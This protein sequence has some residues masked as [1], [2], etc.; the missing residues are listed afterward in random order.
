MKNRLTPMRF[1]GGFDGL[2]LPQFG[3]KKKIAELLPGNQHS[4]RLFSLSPEMLCNLCCNKFESTD[5]DE[6]E[7]IPKNNLEEQE[8]HKPLSAT[9]ET[10][11]FLHLVKTKLMHEEQKV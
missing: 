6:Q 10:I 8:Q 11:T 9:T 2:Q 7:S 1:L 3:L 4:M 5:C